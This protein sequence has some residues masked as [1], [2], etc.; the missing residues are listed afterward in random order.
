VLSSPSLFAPLPSLYSSRSCPILNK[1]L[2]TSG[3]EIPV[4][5]NTFSPSLPP[6]PPTGELG[7]PSPPSPSSMPFSWMDSSTKVGRSNLMAAIERYWPVMACLIW[8]LCLVVISCLGAA[9]LFDWASS[10]SIMIRQA[11]SNSAIGRARRWPAAACCWKTSV[12][13]LV[14]PFSGVRK[15][16]RQ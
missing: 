5:P 14:I 12:R 15:P 7:C 3:D 16:S 4:L 9:G 11:A 8:N 6:P 13:K 10:P 1:N 2:F